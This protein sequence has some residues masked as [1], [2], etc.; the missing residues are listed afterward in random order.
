M[1]HMIAT[2]TQTQPRSI[3]EHMIAHDNL[4]GQLSAF[5]LCCKVD[6]L[7][8]RTIEDYEGKIG[9]FI[10]FCSS[11]GRETA[12]EITATCVRLFMLELQKRCSPVS[13]NCYYRCVKRFFNWMVAEG[14]L[15]DNPMASIRHPRMPQTII[16]PFTAQN[17][18]DML[19]LCDG[20]PDR[21]IHFIDVR[22]KAITLMLLDT[23][24]RVSEL[25]NIQVKDIDIDHGTIRVMGKGAKERVVGIGRKAQKALLKY[26]LM[27]KDGLS[28]LWVNLKRK[29]LTVRGVRRMFRVLGE[30]AE[31]GKEVRCSPHTFRHTFATEA[32]KNGANL[33]EVQSLLGH[34]TLIMTRRYAA[35]IDSET[36]V[37]NHRAFSPADN[38]KL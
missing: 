2:K 9:A 19:E 37:R 12:E 24:L 38:M 27:R 6:E 15:Q 31:F 33:F 4:T 3:L 35:T 28:C 18:S 36:A 22:N 32:I 14:M 11:S 17:I 16:R 25:I 13:V 26:L 7:S 34:S 20:A 1:M 30:R 5:L 29:P 8:P 23:G 21:A 10:R